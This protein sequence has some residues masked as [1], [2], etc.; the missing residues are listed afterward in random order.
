M[1]KFLLPF[2]TPLILL[3]DVVDGAKNITIKGDGNAIGL[4]AEGAEPLQPSNEKKP[5]MREWN[6][7]CLFSQY[8]ERKGLTDALWGQL[9]GPS[10]TVALVGL[11]GMG[12]VGKT[13]LAMHAVQHPPRDYTFRAW[14]NAE[15]KDLLR[16]QYL[17]LGSELHL[18]SDGMSEEQKIHKVKNLLDSQSSTLLIYDNAPNMEILAEFLPNNGHTLITS[19]NYNLPN[20]IEVDVMTEDEA[21]MLLKALLPRTLQTGDDF[22]KQAQSLVSELG[23][24]PLAIAQSGAYMAE[25][26]LDI[27][28][29]ATLYKTNKEQLLSSKILPAGDSHEAIYVSWDM[30][31]KSIEQHPNGDNATIVLDFIAYCYPE[32]I[33]KSLLMQYLCGNT[34]GQAEITLNEALKILR[35][36]SLIKVSQ[37]SVSVHRLVHDWIRHRHNEAD[38]LNILKKALS[39]I[40][41][42]YPRE[43]KSEEQIELVKALAPNVDYLLSQLQPLVAAVDVVDLMSILADCYFTLGKYNKGNYDKSKHFFDQALALSEKNLGPDHITTAKIL[44]C[45]GLLSREMGDYQKT[46][47][48]YDRAMAICEKQGQSESFFMACILDSYGSLWNALRELLKAAPCYSD[49]N[50]ICKKLYQGSF[51]GKPKVALIFGNVCRVYEGLGNHLKAKESYEYLLKNKKQIFGDKDH[52]NMAKLFRDY[53]LVCSVV[54]EWDRA[55]KYYLKALRIYQMHY[56][57]EHPECAILL[58]LIGI[59]WRYRGEYSKS[60]ECCTT[61]RNISEKYYGPSHPEVGKAIHN[62]AHTFMCLGEFEQAEAC[63]RR[64][65]EIKTNTPLQY[66][67]VGVSHLRLARF[68]IQQHKYTEAEQSLAEAQKFFKGEKL[69]VHYNITL[70]LTQQSIEEAFGHYTQAYLDFKNA[71]LDAKKI[72]GHGLHVCMRRYEIPSLRLRQLTVDKAKQDEA[73]TYYKKATKLVCK[74]FGEEHYYTAYYHDLFGQV[75]EQHGDLWNAKKQYKKALKIIRMQSFKD[76]RL[77]ELWRQNEQCVQQRISEVKKLKE[78][79]HPLILKVKMCP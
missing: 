19:R 58:N 30:N 7:P 75:L 77:T 47:Q 57:V 8:V 23:Y 51:E 54:G 5:L 56:G 25:N 40:Q 6:L 38:K 70:Q 67:N 32:N 42:L 12:G 11:H 60:L 28:H 45:I 78:Q 26:M 37:Q 35:Q 10:K 53:G 39:T 46:K 52:P 62:L 69:F 27:P 76:P 49:A 18:F 68:Y 59:L 50:N 74:L 1:F 2:L 20:A 65:L 61:A 43:E 24:L 79:W 63:Y 34:N 31:Y 36:Y 13:F 33:P 64:A 44:Y 41:A 17:A 73:L 72:Y 21:L 22:L 3:G 55:H 15:S 14:F 48:S 16:A 66:L 4:A 71:F 9:T 29:Y